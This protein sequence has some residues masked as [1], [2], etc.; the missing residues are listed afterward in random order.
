MAI[1]P[2]HHFTFMIFT[3]LLSFVSGAMRVSTKT[4][5]LP[6]YMRVA[7]A[8]YA[9]NN[10]LIFYNKTSDIGVTFNIVDDDGSNL[11]TL[12]AG[13]L[14]LQRANG[15]R[16]MPFWDNRRVLIGDAVLECA[17]TLD[18]CQN[19]EMVYIEYPKEIVESNKTFWIWSEIVISPD[20]NMIGWTTL[21]H[22]GAYVF[23]G[24]LVRGKDKYI[25]ENPKLIS[26]PRYTIEDP[27]HPGYVIPQMIRG[28]EIKQFLRGGTALT[29]AGASG[30][31]LTK[32][33]FQDLLTEEVSSLSNE[34]GYEE[35]MIVSPDER[36]GLVM[37]TRFSPKTNCAIFGLL[38]RPYSTLALAGLINAIYTYSV[39][40]VRNF[41]REGNIGPVLVELERSINEKG[42]HGIPLHDEK[43]EW[44]YRSPMSW[45]TSSKKVAWMEV[46]KSGIRRIRVATIDGYQ[47][48]NPYPTRETPLG[49]IPYAKELSAVFPDPPTIYTPGK[50]KGRYSGDIEYSIQHGESTTVTTMKYNN[51]SNDGQVFYNGEESSTSG[52]TIMSK[53]LEYRA[54]VRMTGQ[55][56]GEMNCAIVFTESGG[57]DKSQSSGHATYNGKTVTVDEMS[58]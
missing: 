42:Y 16:V 44:M 18:N 35:T 14:H 3:A 53:Q 38:P 7:S 33:V 11:K 56:E 23:L 12:W 55:E 46:N 17:P 31:G 26:S 29:L 4:V 28:G 8:S 21:L 49:K 5:P 52:T 1:Q 43:G 2:I 58:D 19:S 37:S 47:A 25:I 41:E 48:R 40:S 45:H 34:P 51:F 54:N 6:D 20:S 50:I 30:A 32:S 39:T 9:S 36:L 15:I 13:D 22:T 24:E 10:K 57:I 27:E